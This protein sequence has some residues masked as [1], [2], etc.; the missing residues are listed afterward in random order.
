M[1]IVPCPA[2]RRLPIGKIL[3]S[4][5]NFFRWSHT[6]ARKN[7]KRFRGTAKLWPGRRRDRRADIGIVCDG[8]LKAF[9]SAIKKTIFHTFL[10]Y[11]EGNSEPCQ[12]RAIYVLS[13]YVLRILPDISPRCFRIYPLKPTSVIIFTRRRLRKMV[14]RNKE[15][16]LKD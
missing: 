16:W 5:Y 9:K 8:L 1:P 7:L 13:M 2:A 14:Y 15:I 3:Q 11:P 6:T 4:D 12:L 10:R